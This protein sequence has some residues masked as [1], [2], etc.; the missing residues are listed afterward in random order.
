MKLSIVIPHYQ[1]DQGKIFPLLSSIKNQVGVNFNEV[2][3]II[4]DDGPEAIPL[5][6]DFMELFNS[7]V[8][9]RYFK[10]P[11]NIGRGLCRQYGLNR[12]QGDYVMFCDADDRLHSVAVLGLF[13]KEIETNRPDLCLSQFIQEKIVDGKHQY[14]TIS[15]DSVWLHGKAFNRKFLEYRNIEFHSDIELYE[16]VYFVGLAYNLAERISS[17]PFPTY[18]WINNEESVTRKDNNLFD[19][20]EFCSLIKST[21]LKF[22][23]LE[24]EKLYTRFHRYTAPMHA[25]YSKSTR[26]TKLF[27]GFRSSPAPIFSSTASRSLSPRPPSRSIY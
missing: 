23:R 9:I 5:G 22:E 17:I 21:D 26:V 4:V 16:D 2:E 18:V 19:T 6:D 12:S 13:L 27:P 8:N 11:G 20:K 1:E 25:Y 24:K 3:V 10:L 14:G 15:N 7:I